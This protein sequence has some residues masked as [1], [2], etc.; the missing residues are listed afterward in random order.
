MT[1]VKDVASGEAKKTTLRDWIILPVLS[2]LTAGAIVG[3][4]VLGAKHLFKVSDTSV[5]S[6][7]V[8]TDPTTGTRGIP[9]TVCRQKSFESD[10]TEFKFNNCGDRT[11]LNCGP[12]PPGTY[13][14]V[15]VGSS[16]AEGVWVPMDKTFAALL[17][18]ELSSI[19]GRKVQVYD[20]AINWGTP[21]VVD[22]RLNKVLAAEPDMILWPLTPWDIENAPLVIP[23][24]PSFEA[25]KTKAAN[26]KR[27]G[28]LERLHNKLTSLGVAGAV[29][30]GWS[31]LLDAF[32]QTE[33]GQ[34]LQHYFY[35]SQTQYLKHYLMQGESAAFLRTDLSPT[36]RE[37]LASFDNYVGDL[38]LTS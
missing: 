11:M 12:K 35:K 23:Y 10:L 13:R 26:I 38:T 32:Q 30:L 15:M 24:V 19:T 7:L 25:A 18:A 34:L 33:T 3:G 22:L 9:N 21:H 8:L 36:L 1:Q 2:L 37:N 20:E 14:V 16:F 17:P 29:R 5:L 6:C 28:R 27:E 4:T 31:R